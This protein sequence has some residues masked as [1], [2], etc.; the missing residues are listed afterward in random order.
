M[1]KCVKYVKLR[2]M[3]KIIDFSIKHTFLRKSAQIV[4]AHSTGLSLVLIN[5]DNVTVVRLTQVWPESPKS[6]K[7]SIS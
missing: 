5:D 4:V 7:S 2:K 3:H 1:Q 6:S